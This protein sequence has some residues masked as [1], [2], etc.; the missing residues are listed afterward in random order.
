M[1]NQELKEFITVKQL[2]KELRISRSLL[3]KWQTMGIPSMQQGQ[4]GKLFF[5]IPTVREWL[6]NQ[7]KS[8]KPK[9][10]K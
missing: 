1:K 8:N 9:K 5:H 3:Q 2:L 6:I 4:G 10:K 7:T